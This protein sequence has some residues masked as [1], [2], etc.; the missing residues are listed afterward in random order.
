MVEQ[1]VKIVIFALTDLRIIRYNI[2]AK[3][4]INGKELNKEE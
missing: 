1:S 3:S 2:C 4:L